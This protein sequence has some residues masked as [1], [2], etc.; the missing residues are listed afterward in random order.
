MTSVFGAED[1]E[2]LHDLEEA[3]RLFQA[4]GDPTRLAILQILGENER[5]VGDLVRALDAPQPKVSQHLKVLRD[6][7]L[8]TCRKDGRQVWYGMDRGKIPGG[9]RFAAGPPRPS[10]GPPS[11][12]PPPRKA[13][14]RA[15]PVIRGGDLDTHL[16]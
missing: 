10:T 1:D 2:P 13:P 11:D 3:A 8:V 7:G 14:P 16:L 6:V 4:L 5:T 15:A 12:A 9:I